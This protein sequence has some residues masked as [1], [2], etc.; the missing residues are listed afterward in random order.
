MDGVGVDEIEDLASKIALVIASGR[1]PQTIEEAQTYARTLA[2]LQFSVV[3]GLQDGVNAWTKA[4]G[5]VYIDAE[6]D[7]AYGQWDKK[8]TVV[9]DENELYNFLASKGANPANYKRPDLVKLKTLL[10]S[11]EGRERMEG[12]EKYVVIDTSVA[13]GLKKNLLKNP[14]KAAVEKPAGKV[15]DRSTYHLGPKGVVEK[16][17][18]VKYTPAPRVAAK[19]EEK[20]ELVG[21]GVMPPA[22]ITA[23]S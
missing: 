13:F 23:K 15:V 2:V 3:D 9:H 16:A 12:L 14:R 10:T 18:V 4:N 1:A 6:K 8:T 20:R 19:T 5:P 21:C 22:A 7:Q 17:Q 11:S